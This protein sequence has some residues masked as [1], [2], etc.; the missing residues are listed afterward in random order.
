MEARNASLP[1]LDLFSPPVVQKMVERE[2]TM[3][4]RPVTQLSD[5]TPIIF[6]ITEQK[7]FLDLYNSQL[8]VKMKILKKDNTAI[9]ADKKVAPVNNVLHSLFEKISVYIEG[10][11][12]TTSNKDYP[13]KAMFST[14]LAYQKGAKESQLQAQGYFKDDSDDADQITGNV[15]ANKRQKMFEKSN[16]VELQGPLYEDIF[17]QKRFLPNNLRLTIKLDR[18]SQEFFLLN[19]EPTGSYKIHLEDVIFKAR[20]VELY[21]PVQYAIAKK[22]ENKP[23]LFPYTRREIR[24]DNLPMGFTSGTFDNIFPNQLPSRI[25][26][27]FVSS[28]NYNGHKKKNPYILTNFGLTRISLSVNNNTIASY[29]P[30]FDSKQGTGVAPCYL[31]LYETF[32][33]LG[34][35]FGNDITLFD[36][37]HSCTMY[38]F[39]IKPSYDCTYEPDH[40]HVRLSIHFKQPLTEA[41]CLL[42]HAETPCLM[43]ITGTRNVT[44][45]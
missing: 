17:M 1:Q 13:Y 16:S 11:E 22:M 40:G 2:Y 4:Y 29:T 37:V 39:N 34:N 27:T 45:K 38:A 21:P 44:L 19:L 9:M 14:L 26:I 32:R 28:E 41:V 15:G 20:M 42:V 10:K 3:E 24:V 43:E 18:T 31:S 8:Y 36:Y 30:S 23:A 35:D 6:D 12:I 7:H 25:L 5:D 33:E